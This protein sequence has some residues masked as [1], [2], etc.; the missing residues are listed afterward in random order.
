[1]KWTVTK[2]LG[3]INFEIREHGDRM[4]LIAGCRGTEAKV[5]RT[6]QHKDAGWVAEVWSREFVRAL[7]PEAKQASVQ[8]ATP[9]AEGMGVALNRANAEL[10]ARKQSEP[11]TLTVEK[12]S[13][14]ALDM[15]MTETIL[16]PSKPLKFW[17][18]TETTAVEALREILGTSRAQYCDDLRADKLGV[19]EG[20]MLTL[21]ELEGLVADEL[22]AK[23][24]EK[25]EARAQKESAYAKK[26]AEAKATGKPVVLRT[27]IAE[28]D[29]TAVE[30]S[31]DA[32]TVWLHPNGQET[33]TRV[34]TH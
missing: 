22:A 29:G 17:S 21:A 13:Y 3:T 34:H 15:D 33:R 8:I 1:M 28:C 12:H 25:A 7:A 18:A 9:L 23:A 10:I 19:A 30:C 31:L 6:Y 26:L 20:A 16:V 27:Y 32:V 11:L 5:S 2:P 14:F 4:L 24:Q